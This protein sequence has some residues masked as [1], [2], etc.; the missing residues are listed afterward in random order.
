[1]SDLSDIVQVTISR[2]TT[3]VSQPSFGVPAILT[4]FL[5]SKTNPAFTRARFYGSLAEMTA[6]GWSGSDAV[7][8]AA[9]LIFSQSPVV[10]KILVGRKDAADADWAAALNAVQ[11]EESNWY[12]F[13]IIPESG[14]EVAEIKEAMAWTETQKKIFFYNT[15]SADAYNSGVT[16]DLGYFAKNGAYERTVSTFHKTAESYMECAMQG[17]AL[18]FDP[19]SQTWAYKTL[20][21]VQAYALTTAQRTALLD[22]HY[23]VYT[24]RG[25]VNVT[26]DGNVA[27]GEFIDVIRGLDW[28]E[29]ALEVAIFGNLVNKRKMPYDDTGIALIQNSV[30][31]V[32]KLAERKGVLQPGTSKVQVPLYADISTN[33]ILSR[34]LPDVKFSALIQGAIHKVKINGTVTV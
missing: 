1:M 25:G 23:N 4:E 22:K 3:A 29:S 32:L 16:T 30:S 33:D 27:S 26:E 12:T 9:T 31:S 18:P 5:T 24:T 8:D 2:E 17:E 14:T 28:L 21:G 15:T 7:Y 34:T 20:S 11:A 10:E 19:G 13:S 6:D